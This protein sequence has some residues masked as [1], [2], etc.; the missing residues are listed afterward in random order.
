MIDTI[1]ALSS[2]SPPA[3]IAIVRISGPSA[4]RAVEQMAGPLAAPRRAVLRTIRDHEG[5]V[6]DEAIVLIF[7]G[8][9]SA[10][11]EDC[12]EFHC[13]GGRAV[14]SAILAALGAVSGLRAAEPGEFTRRAFGNGKID[15]AQAESLGDLLAAETELQRRVAQAGV[16]GLLSGMVERWRA[17]VLMLS[18]MIEAA[19]DFS[20]EDD[21]DA[22]PR[23]FAKLCQPLEEEIAHALARPRAERL[24]DGIRVVL[25]GPPNSG[26]SSLFN[27]LLGDGAAIVS[28]IAGTTRDV[29]ERSVAFAGL[30]F[31]LVDTAGLRE[32]GAGEIEAIGIARAHDQIDS[33]DIVLWLGAEGRGPDCALEVETKI[34]QFESPRKLRPAWRVSSIHGTGL[35]ELEAELVTR[36]ALLLP[37]PND[38]PVNARQAELLSDALFNLADATSSDLLIKAE[39]LRRARLAFDRL[40]GSTGTEDMLDTLFGRFC[41]GK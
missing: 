23:D 12:A 20:D 35:K 9:A 31:V 5:V 25:A 29:I 40:L 37:K 1:F 33:A 16:G 8:P 13:H 3:G 28:P 30:P 15:L 14:V 26:K 24:R 36:A 38:A 4:F 39:A 32:G 34:D 41:I 2:G 19:L 22:L 7:P 21:V 10:T 27:A 17:E 11:G 6:L 18:A